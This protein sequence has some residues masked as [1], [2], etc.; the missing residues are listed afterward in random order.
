MIQNVR[1]TTFRACLT[2]LGATALTACAGENL[3]QFEIGTTGGG[4]GLTIT[5]PED[6]A[7]IGLNSS[8]GVGFD[9]ADPAAAASYTITGRYVGGE[10]DA[11]EPFDEVLE[12]NLN[13]AAVFSTLSPAA[14]QV[15]GDV[16]VVVVLTDNEGATGRDS[17]RISIT[18]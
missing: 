5:T 11:Y 12:E 18:N 6:G 14:G 15:V 2:L 13:V 7:T 17:V 4:A 16:Y 1:R 9:I 8:L 3:F 10:T